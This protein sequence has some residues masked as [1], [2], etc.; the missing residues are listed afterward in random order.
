MTGR[1]RWSVVLRTL[2][3]GIPRLARAGTLALTFLTVVPVRSVGAVVSDDDL[4]AS[5]FAYPLVGGAIGLV[6]AVLSWRLSR[7]G[8]APGVS[9]FLLVTAGVA[10]TGGLHLDGLADSADGLFLGGDRARRL[11]VMRDPHV[12]SFGVTAIVL[13]V[14]G[15]YAVLSALPDPQRWRAVL[16]AAVVSRSLVLVSAGQAGYARPQG[17]GR[18]LVEATTFRD[19]LGAAL[20]ALAAGWAASGASGFLAAFLTIAL[21]CAITGFAARR[22]GGVTGDTLGALIETGELLFL[23]ALHIASV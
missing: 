9:A 7:A 11:S 5:R 19:A 20:V 14:A 16:G 4:A 17:T 15:R 21:A 6:L 1:A 2:K 18:I 13:A 22:L 8:V 23:L 10:L 12:G 3:D